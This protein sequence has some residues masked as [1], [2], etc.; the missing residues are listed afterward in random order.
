MRLD[1][2]NILNTIMPQDATTRTLQAK[3]VATLTEGVSIK[4]FI[5]T[6]EDEMRSADCLHCGAQPYCRLYTALMYYSLG[7]VARAKDLTEQA[8]LAFRIIALSWN[9]ALSYWLMGILH[10]EDHEHALAERSL[11]RALEVLQFKIHELQI[12][13]NYNEANLGKECAAL[14]KQ[15]LM[16]AHT[17]YTSP[18]QYKASETQL[19]QESTPAGYLIIPW[20]PIYEGVQAGA[21]SPIW[22]DTPYQEKTELYQ[23]IL[24]GIRCN[25]LSVHKWDRRISMDSQKQYA[26]AKVRGHSMEKAVPTPINEDD[27]VLFY[28]ADQAV[29]ASIVVVAQQEGADVSHI[30]KQVDPDR[31]LLLSNT[32]RKGAEY[33]PIPL[34]PERHRIVG[35]VLAV[36]K[37]VNE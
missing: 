17:S 35:I 6:L 13:S 37:P 9:E 3:A 7:N 2:R 29:S 10:L 15:A 25:I 1:A 19:A 36:A 28:R 33:E 14:I 23:V 27:Y 16:E 30:V 21:K 11:E 4:E 12:E 20:L 24:Q 34:D 31:R 22:I 8:I 5:D 32:A 18:L 26:W